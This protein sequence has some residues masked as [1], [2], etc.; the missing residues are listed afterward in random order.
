MTGERMLVPTSLV[1][2]GPTARIVITDITGERSVSLVDPIVM[3]RF[4]VWDG[5][6]TGPERLA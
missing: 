3:A 2:K 1:A 6:G 4:N 5:P